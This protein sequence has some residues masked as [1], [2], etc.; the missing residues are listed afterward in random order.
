M[1]DLENGLFQST[2]AAPEYVEHGNRSPFVTA[3]LKNQGQNFFAFKDGNAQSGR[4]QHSHTAE[5]ADVAT[6]YSR[7]PGRLD[8]PGHRCDNSKGHRILLR[9]RHD[10]GPADGCGREIGA[11]QTSFRSVNGRSEPVAV[12]ADSGL[13][14]LA[15]ADDSGNPRRAYIRHQAAVMTPSKRI[16]WTRCCCHHRCPGRSTFL[17]HRE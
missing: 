14:D 13:D 4:S 7:A 1:A 9:R 3:T 8:R 12:D 2:P 6:R 17:V 11:G 15:A 16:R 5:R 10:G